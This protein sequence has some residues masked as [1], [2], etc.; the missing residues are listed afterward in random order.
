MKKEIPEQ[1]VLL[2]DLFF[3]QFMRVTPRHGNTSHSDALSLREERSS[4]RLDFA[5]AKL[6][7]PRTDALQGS[8]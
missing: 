8:L 6:V 7:S 1:G 3:V 2:R 5:S 4:T